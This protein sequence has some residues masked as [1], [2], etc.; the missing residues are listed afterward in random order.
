MT[1]PFRIELAGNES[2]LGVQVDE[3]SDLP[4]ALVN[5]RR[6]QQMAPGVSRV[7]NTLAA[8]EAASGDVGRAAA[9]TKASM[10]R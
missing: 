2:G 3:A 5:A 4:A 7:L 1:S 6:A 10:A 9:D 8:I